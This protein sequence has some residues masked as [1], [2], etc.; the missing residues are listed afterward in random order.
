[1][2]TDSDQ[3][4]LVLTRILRAPRERVFR[5]WTDP[6]QMVRWWWPSAHPRPRCE[7]DFRVGG[8]YRFVAL[9]DA[10]EQ[11]R[12]ARDQVVRGT[13][14]HIAAPARLVF[15]W[16][17]EDGE[18][19]IWCDTM[20]EVTLE[21]RGTSTLLTLD[22]ATFSTVAHCTEHT[23]GWGACLDRLIHFIEHQHPQHH[24]HGDLRQHAGQ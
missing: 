19:D 1:M 23:V 16:L 24:A 3:R 17:R 21:Q 22:Q 20:V 11:T 4:A 14:T 12:S 10:G 2:R 5:A 18:G 8:T 13:Y 15:T 7:K 9:P 6:E